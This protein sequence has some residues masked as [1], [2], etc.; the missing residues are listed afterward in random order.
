[1]ADRP[2]R[3]GYGRTNARYNSA[4]SLHEADRRGTRAV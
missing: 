3:G 2:G 4:G 1:L